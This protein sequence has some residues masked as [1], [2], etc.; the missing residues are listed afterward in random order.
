[1]QSSEVA[2]TSG[3]FLEF[4]RGL[5]FCAQTYSR[6]AVNS[7]PVQKKIW[8]STDSLKN[9]NT[10]LFCDWWKNNRTSKLI[11]H[12]Y[13]G[14]QTV[15]QKYVREQSKS[16]CL[17]STTKMHPQSLW[18]FAVLLI[19]GGLAVTL[20]ICTGF[21]QFSSLNYPVWTAGGKVQFKLGIKSN[22]S[23]S[24]F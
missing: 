20:F 3:V 7:L 24:I 6:T 2:K 16:S 14:R 19:F 4:S 5:L 13:V 21:L 1:M 23:N 22:S 12:W 10:A 11:L 9:N 15:A 17:K 8:H 18:I